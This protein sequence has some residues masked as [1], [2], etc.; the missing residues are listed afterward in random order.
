MVS[1]GVNSFTQ[2]IPI[3]SWQSW[4]LIGRLNTAMGL[5][6]DTDH[7]RRLQIELVSYLSKALGE[8]ADQA[9]PLD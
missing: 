8:S 4:L 9:P 5:Y 6:T 3:Q 7:L 1:V 2:A